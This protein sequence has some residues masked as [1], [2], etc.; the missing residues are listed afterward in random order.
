MLIS[1][2]DV[3]LADA[4]RPVREKRLMWSQYYERK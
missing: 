4:L 1:R 2:D 3:Q